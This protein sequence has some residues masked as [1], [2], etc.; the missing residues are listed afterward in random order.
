MEQKLFFIGVSMGV[1]TWFT[2]NFIAKK[3]FEK[4]NFTGLWHGLYCIAASLIILTVIST[5]LDGGVAPYPVSRPSAGRIMLWLAVALGAGLWG[6]FKTAKK[7]ANEHETIMKG[8]LEWAETIFYAVI[9]ASVAMYFFIQAFKIPSASMRSS[10]LEGDHLFVNKFIY[11]VRIPLTQKRFFT[12]HKV[13]KGEI[14]VFRF[15]SDN[16]A[17]IHC[18][19]IQYGKDFIKRVIA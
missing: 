13:Q 3:F 15:P 5:N 18:G 8:D 12:A 6:F 9:M 10:L 7:P 4:R 19:G 11:G 2:K 17:E 14:V 1:F 16:P